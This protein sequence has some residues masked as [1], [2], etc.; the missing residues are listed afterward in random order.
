MTEYF[1]LKTAATSLFKPID[2]DY[3]LYQ[4]IM[5]K[6]HFEKIPKDKICYYKYS[7]EVEMPDVMLRPTF[8]V[9]SSIYNI[10][11]LYNENIEWKSLQVFPDVLDYVREMVKSYWI[12]CLPEYKCLHEEAIVLPNGTVDRLILNRSK[13]RNVDIFRVADARVG[14]NLVVVSLPLAE[15][16]NRR[17]V[18]GVSIERVEVK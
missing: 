10:V 17:N 3:K 14:E 6:E 11:K 18:Y 5:T 4:H 13:M 8:M 2:F 9:G 12:P 1:L 16:I 7:V 15:S